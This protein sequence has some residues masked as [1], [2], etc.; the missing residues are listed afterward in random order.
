[1]EWLKDSFEG[2]TR[3]NRINRNKVN[4]VWYYVINY[5]CIF[6]HISEPLNG[7]QSF[8]EVGRIYLN[9]KMRKI[10]TQQNPPT[11][12]ILVGQITKSEAL[13]REKASK[14]HQMTTL[15]LISGFGFDGGGGVYKLGT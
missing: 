1:M 9:N 8:L 3:G 4:H 13:R 5:S 6:L 2:E 11:Q 7:S 15:E 12:I 14:R 10:F